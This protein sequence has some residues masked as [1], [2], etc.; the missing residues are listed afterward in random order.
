MNKGFENYLP[1]RIE[2]NKAPIVR[3]KTPIAR[4]FIVFIRSATIK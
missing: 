3:I 2:T 4:H 1:R